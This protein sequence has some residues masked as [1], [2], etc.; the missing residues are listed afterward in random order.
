MHGVRRLRVSFLGPPEDCTGRLR[1]SGMRICLHWCCAPGPAG[2][3]GLA[4]RGYLCLPTFT[5]ACQFPD[6]SR[7]DRSNTGINFPFSLHVEI[8][9]NL[10][11]RSSCHMTPVQPLPMYYVGCSV[12]TRICSVD[13]RRSESDCFLLMLPETPRCARIDISN[14]HVLNLELSDNVCILSS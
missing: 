5:F 3:A 11:P 6:V 14:T 7:R 2:G 12:G 1:A 4:A 13:A 8:S 9:G 10:Q